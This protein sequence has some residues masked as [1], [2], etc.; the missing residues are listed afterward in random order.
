MLCLLDQALWFKLYDDSFC[1]KKGSV[2]TINS[3]SFVNFFVEKEVVNHVL[4]LKDL[5]LIGYFEIINDDKQLIEKE[6]EKLSQSSSQLVIDESNSYTVNQL[7]PKLSNTNWSIKV[8]VTNKSQVKEFTNRLNGNNGKTMRLQLRDHTGQVE[9]VVFNDQCE[10]FSTLELN[11]CYLIR[12]CDIKFSKAA[13]RAWPN[14]LSV[15]YDIIAT[16]NSNFEQCKQP[17]DI[18]L[19]KQVENQSHDSNIQSPSSLY[20]KYQKFTPLNELILKPANSF[21]DVIGAIEQVGDLKSIVK[22]K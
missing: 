12:N 7:T 21:V 2:I 10:R 17:F 5:S 4:K 11:N 20:K 16:K 6:L 18:T 19:S 9:M 22:K 14:E 13:C 1:L 8:T 15:I 3:Y